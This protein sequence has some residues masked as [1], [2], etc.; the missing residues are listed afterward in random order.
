MKILFYATYPNITSGYSRIANIIS[1]YLA[2]KNN[3]I[4]YIGISNFQK[5]ILIN[6][7]F[8]PVLMK[9]IVVKILIY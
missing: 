4:Y 2:E 5:M 7:I 9:M 1:N 6:L 8:K 3:E